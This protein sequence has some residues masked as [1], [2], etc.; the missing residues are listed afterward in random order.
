MN[1]IH[2]HN[3][4]QLL[5]RLSREKSCEIVCLFPVGRGS[6]DLTSIWEKLSLLNSKCMLLEMQDDHEKEKLF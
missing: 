5:C 6:G 2:E 4:I 3:S 1:T